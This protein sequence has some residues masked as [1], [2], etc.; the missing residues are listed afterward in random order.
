MAR[1]ATQ[2]QRPR[3]SRERGRQ[4]L[5]A[6]VDSIRWRIEADYLQ[7]AVNGWEEVKSAFNRASQAGSHVR[8][9]GGG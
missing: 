7:L 9:S 5:K 6:T 3:V 8:M 1:A 4:I 2:M